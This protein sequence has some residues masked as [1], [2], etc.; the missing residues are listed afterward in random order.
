M[1]GFRFELL[2]VDARLAARRGVFHTPRGAI[3]L[4]AF[5]PVGTVGSVKGLEVDQ[6]RATGSRMVLAN[7]YH[8]TLRPGEDVVA[9]L[10]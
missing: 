3:D 8:L 9:A 1:S 2:H 4:P 10:G 5:M 7:T 6:I